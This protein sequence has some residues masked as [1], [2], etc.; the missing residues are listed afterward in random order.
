MVICNL[1]GWMGERFLPRFRARGRECLCPQCE[2]VDFDRHLH[3]VLDSTAG[4]GEASA[5]LAIRPT[6][7]LLARLRRD[8]PIVAIGDPPAADGLLPMTPDRLEFPEGYFRAVV[9]SHVFER[10]DDDG[11]A[12]R[13]ILRALAP[14]GRLLA[15]VAYRVG[16]PTE[17]YDA[18]DR[19]GHLRRYGARDFSERLAAAGF[20]AVERVSDADLFPYHAFDGYDVFIATKAGDPGES[21]AFDYAL[22]RRLQP[23]AET[24][25]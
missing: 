25:T 7:P 8:G 19:H 5:R 22:L 17:T 10:L 24:A 18:P 16:A 3:H 6:R 11:A 21:R 9:C 14:G 12:M 13:E 1:C 4:A 2:S 15:Q 23:E 20:E